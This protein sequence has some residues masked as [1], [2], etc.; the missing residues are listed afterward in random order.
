MFKKKEKLSEQE[1]EEQSRDMDKKQEKWRQT[2]AKNYPEHS[3]CIVCS[4]AIHY[5]KR[6]CSMECKGKYEGVQ[7]KQKKKN[8][9]MYICMCTVLPVMMLVMF[10]FQG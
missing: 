4:R 7:K 9:W 10:M 3:H 6:Y 2:V 5:G 1:L 8:R